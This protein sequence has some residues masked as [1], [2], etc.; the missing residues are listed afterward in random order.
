MNASLKLAGE[1]LEDAAIDKITGGV[2]VEQRDDQERLSR[3]A[4]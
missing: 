2:V 4:R 3:V 1:L